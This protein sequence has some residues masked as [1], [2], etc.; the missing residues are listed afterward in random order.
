MR[1]TF[2]GNIASAIFMGT[3]LLTSCV[4]NGSYDE[5]YDDL[6]SEEL[7]A[8]R[9]F[10][11]DNNGGHSNNNNNNNNKPITEKDIQKAIKWVHNNT[12]GG[13]GECIAYSINAYKKSTRLPDIRVAIGEELLKNEDKGGCDTWEYWY[14]LHAYEKADG[15][16]VGVDGAASVIRSTCGVQECSISDFMSE[17]KSRA[18]LDYNMQTRTYTAPYV[19]IFIIVNDKHVGLLDKIVFSDFGEEIHL[20]DQYGTGSSGPFNRSS[21][22]KVL[23]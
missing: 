8:R 4:G 18:V 19:S 13:A 14:W 11:G 12:S 2:L 6:S 17:A 5:F 20:L 1:K 16:N 21:I 23:R 7:I 10:K 22:S 9:K 15:F 3:V